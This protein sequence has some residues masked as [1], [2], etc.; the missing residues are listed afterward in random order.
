MLNEKLIEPYKMYIYKRSCGQIT[1]DKVEYEIYALINLL[2][3]GTSFSDTIFTLGRYIFKENRC[4]RDF[5]VVMAKDFAKLYKRLSSVLY[6][7]IAVEN[8][9]VL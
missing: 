9:T 7:E 4:V 6:K 3:F 2:M 5:N 8:V 1:V